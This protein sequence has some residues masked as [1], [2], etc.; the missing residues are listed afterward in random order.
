MARGQAFSGK[1][2][3]A[4][5]QKKHSERSQLLMS[6]GAGAA[7]DGDEFSWGGS[8]HAKAAQKAKVEG[9]EGG[10]ELGDADGRKPGGGRKV[11]SGV[12]DLATVFERESDIEV[13]KRK[14]DSTRCVDRDP[15]AGDA[16]AGAKSG[17]ESGAWKERA[18]PTRAMPYPIPVQ[19]DEVPLISIP[20]RPAWSRTMGKKEVEEKE[21]KVYAEWIK[22]VYETHPKDSLNF[23]EHNI[24]VWRQIWRSLEKADVVV[25]CLDARI[26]L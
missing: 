5:M 2:K 24:E 3:K 13:M 1:K 25:L 12:G 10:T 9:R 23:F 4:Q 22:S 14:I 21:E 26:P 19:G 8:R 20:K 18:W 6:V 17:D 16:S 11:V 7:T 15:G